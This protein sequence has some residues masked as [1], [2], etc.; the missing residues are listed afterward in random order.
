[1]EK[2]TYYSLRRNYDELKNIIENE[3]DDVIKRIYQS[4]LDQLKENY[5]LIGEMITLQDISSM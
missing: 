3:P 5:E 4:V 2:K 1:M